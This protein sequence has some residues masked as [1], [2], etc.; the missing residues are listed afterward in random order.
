M[1]KGNKRQGG[2]RSGRQA[3]RKNRDKQFGSRQG[4]KR[5]FVEVTGKVHMS[6]DGFVFVVP[7]GDEKDKTYFCFDNPHAD[8]LCMW[9][10]I[11]TGRTSY[12]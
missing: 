11:T 5:K 3:L 2:A 9:E 10:E 6:R 8:F 7:E 1:K 12:I 4:G